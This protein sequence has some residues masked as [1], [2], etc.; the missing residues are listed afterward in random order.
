VRTEGA[1]H[2]NDRVRVGRPEALLA[3]RLAPADMLGLYFFEAHDANRNEMGSE[4]VWKG[5]GERHG[6]DMGKIERV[7]KVILR[8]E[9]LKGLTS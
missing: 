4:Y 5:H 7:P 6:K 9:T 3:W 1:S 8:R 2:S